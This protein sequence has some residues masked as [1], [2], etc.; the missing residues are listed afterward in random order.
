MTLLDTQTHFKSN[1]SIQKSCIYRSKNGTWSRYWNQNILKLP[2]RFLP[3]NSHS[4]TFFMENCWLRVC[5]FHSLYLECHRQNFKNQY[6]MWLWSTFPKNVIIYFFAILKHSFVEIQT[7]YSPR[8]A[9]FDQSKTLKRTGHTNFGDFQI[10]VPCETVGILSFIKLLFYTFFFI[11][12]IFIDIAYIYQLFLK[13]II[14]QKCFEMQL[15]F[16]VLDIQSQ[17]LPKLAIETLLSGFDSWT[18]SLNGPQQPKWWTIKFFHVIRTH[19]RTDPQVW[20]LWPQSQL[21]DF[22]MWKF[23]Q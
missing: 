1:F 16:D 9:V 12:K 7:H 15:L 13:N 5:P 18:P 14:V 4:K 21:S 20:F 19:N 23:I 8:K 11:E 10:F 2:S 6:M 3:S 17:F 22:E